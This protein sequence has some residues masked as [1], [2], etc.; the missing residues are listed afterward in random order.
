M[1]IAETTVTPRVSVESHRPAPGAQ[2]APLGRIASSDSPSV[3]A[4]VMVPRVPMIG[5]QRATLRL[6]PTSPESSSPLFTANRLLQRSFTPFESL[7]ASPAVIRCRELT[8]ALRESR[9]VRPDTSIRESL[10]ATRSQPNGEALYLHAIEQIA[11]D[12]RSNTANRVDHARLV[13]DSLRDPAA[14][15]GRGHVAQAVYQRIEPA[16]QQT[17]LLDRDGRLTQG[18]R[19]AL[20]GERTPLPTARPDVGGPSWSRNLGSFN[21]TR[22]DVELPSNASDYMSYKPYRFGT[23]RT[24]ET[25]KRVAE[26]YRQ[27]TGMKLR[28][29]DISKRGGGPIPDHSSHRTGKI[30]DI[31][32]AFN[33]GRTT[34]EPDR[35]SVNATWRSPAYDRNA[36]RKL[37][38]IIKAIRP[39]AQILFNDPVLVREGLVRKYPNHD[40]HLHVQKLT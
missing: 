23:A 13:L 12:I 28:V 20:L 25:I 17:P 5:A 38:K 16:T 11:G 3:L 14:E 24:I 37:I 33:D 9:P 26:R 34:A 39:E 7:S 10:L 36:T 30:F 2:A 15:D 32:M 1:T 21:N 31:D 18:E 19:L 6:E 22:I 27:Q 40:N 8:E 4:D 35:D 29:G